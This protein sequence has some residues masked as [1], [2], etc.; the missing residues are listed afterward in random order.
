IRY[1]WVQPFY[2]QGNNASNF[3]P[4]VYNPANAVTVTPN[5]TITPG[6]GNPYNGLIRAGDGG[7]A[8]QQIRVPNVNTALFPLI[9]LGAP[10]GFYKMNGAVGPRFGFAWAADEKTSV[11]GGFGL[12]YYRPQGNLI[13]SQLNLPPWL[14]NAQFGNGNLATLGSLSANNTAL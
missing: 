3:D 6:A 12:F 2:L 1:Q 7:P 5:G 14:N 10:R 9:P 8:H 13:F 4:A 11:R